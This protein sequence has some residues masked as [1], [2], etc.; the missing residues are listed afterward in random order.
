MVL[1]EITPYGCGMIGLIA[2][3][4]W[5]AIRVRKRLA[6]GSR[7]K[8]GCIVTGYIALVVF[9]IGLLSIG[10]TSIFVKSSVESITAIIKGERYNAKVVNWTSRW[11]DNDEG[12]RD[13]HFAPVLGFTDSGGSYITRSLGY[14]SSKK[15]TQGEEYTIYYDAETDNIFVWGFSTIAMF[16][17]MLLMG[18]ILLFA[19]YGLIRFALGQNMDNYWDICKKFGSVFFIPFIMITFDA[20][21]IY[22][23]SRGGYPVWVTGI[24]IFFIL[25]LTLSIWGYINMIRTKGAPKWKRTSTTTWEAD[26]DDEDREDDEDEDED[27]DE[28]EYGDNEDGAGPVIGDEQEKPALPYNKNADN[29]RKTY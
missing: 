3:S 17:G 7:R 21:L 4:I 12:G 5:V 26:W 1:L 24:L 6:E 14:S 28:D 15:P 29:Y 13:E 19:F 18:T 20:L 9:C 8:S 11:E 10:I 2:F 16:I 25:V 23:L 27:W 22:A